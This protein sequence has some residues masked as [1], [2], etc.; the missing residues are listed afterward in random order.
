MLIL[1]QE[2]SVT[3]HICIHYISYNIIDEMTHKVSP[4][5]LKGFQ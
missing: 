3:G 2:W 1:G 5:G 4:D